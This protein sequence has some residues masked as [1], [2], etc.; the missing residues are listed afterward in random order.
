MNIDVSTIKKADRISHTAVGT[1]QL[2]LIELFCYRGSFILDNQCLILNLSQVSCRERQMRVTCFSC[3]YQ[4]VQLLD[5]KVT[6]GLLFFLPL[7]SSLPFSCFYLENA[8]NFLCVHIFVQLHFLLLVASLV[9]FP[10]TKKKCGFVSKT[11]N[12]G[13]NYLIT[14]GKVN[15]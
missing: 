8:G 13:F 5:D 12:C 3:S 14:S 15:K 10:K 6:L 1:L 7:L 4:M 2:M 11:K 9:V